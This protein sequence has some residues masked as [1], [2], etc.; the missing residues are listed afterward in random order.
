MAS[1]RVAR[2]RAADVAAA[3]SLQRRVETGFSAASSST[4]G[5]AAWAT[6]AHRL[7]DGRRT[8]PRA[9]S[10]SAISKGLG[11]SV[12]VDNHSVAVALRAAKSRVWATTPYFVPDSA[13]QRLLCEAAMRG[14]DVRLLVPGK[15]F[16]G[17]RRS[18]DAFAA[19]IRRLVALGGAAREI[20][21]AQLA[22][23]RSSEAMLQTGL[24]VTP[25]PTAV[26]GTARP[27]ASV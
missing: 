12:V 24:P 20:D 27:S 5:S 26:C 8:S 2:V 19:A 15:S 23:S 4:R 25:R 10:P 21:Y 18:A 9:R 22:V 1:S 17:D 13:T 7:L 3:V 6:L 11:Q 16:F 14:A